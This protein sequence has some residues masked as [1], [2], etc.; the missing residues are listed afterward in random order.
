MTAD[1]LH[2]HVGG[3]CCKGGLSTP[4]QGAAYL[5]STA[6]LYILRAVLVDSEHQALNA[7]VAWPEPLRPRPHAPTA[8]WWVRTDGQC[9]QAVEQTQ[10]GAIW[11]VVQVGARQPRPGGLPRSTTLLVATAVPHDPHMAGHMLEHQPEDTGH[12]VVHQCGRPAWLREHLTAFRSLAS[13][14]NGAKIWFH[15]HPAARPNDT[16]ALHVGQL[17][18]GHPEVKLHSAALNAGWLSPTGYY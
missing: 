18:P 3:Y 17:A 11:V 4:S 14:V 7:D 15:D 1:G 8:V 2:L 16:L 12:L 10:L 6:L 13:T 5:P 9:A